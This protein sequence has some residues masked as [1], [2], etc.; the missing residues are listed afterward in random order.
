MLLLS[1]E[2][3]QVF[4]NDYSQQDNSALTEVRQR[5][6]VRVNTMYDKESIRFVADYPFELDEQ[7]T[8]RYCCPICLRYFNNI[9]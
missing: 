6:P 9:L 3:T 4:S 1:M 7:M 5:S 8:F 2:P